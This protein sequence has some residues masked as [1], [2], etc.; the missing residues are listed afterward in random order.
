MREPT[1]NNGTKID[2]HEIVNFK[3]TEDWCINNSNYFSSDTR[4]DQGGMMRNFKNE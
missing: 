4:S 1:K 3:T 2:D